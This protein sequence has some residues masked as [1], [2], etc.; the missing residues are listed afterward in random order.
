MSSEKLTVGARLA[1]GFGATTALGVLLAGLATWQMRSLSTALE[2]VAQDRIPK[3]TLATQI[4]DDLNLT[5]RSARN[6]VISAEPEFRQAELQRI[7]KA[8]EGVVERMA[9]LDRIINLPKARETFQRMS[10]QRERYGSGLDQLITLAQKGEHD[11]AAEFIVKQLRPLQNDLFKSIDE[12]MQLQ[13]DA[14]ESLATNGAAAAQSSAVTQMLL[15]LTL[16]L[17][18]GGTGWALARHLRRALGAEPQQVS[19]AVQ[20][21]AGGDLSQAIELRAG[22]AS[23]VMANVQQMQ[24]ALAAT[25]TQVRSTAEGVATASSQI[26]QGNQDLSQRTEEQASALQQTAATMTELNETV[27]HNADNARQANQLAGSASEAATRGG[28]VVGQVVQ[29]MDGISES[30]RRIADIIGVIDGIAFQTNI[31]ALNAAV[32]AARAGEQGRGFAVV[33]GEVRTLAQRS[34]EAAR[35]IKTLITRSVEQVEQ[36]SQLVGDAGTRMNEIVDAIRRVADIVGEISSASAEQ[37]TGVNQVGDAVNQMDQVTQ[38]NAALVEESAAAAESLRQQA[39]QLVDAMAVF[40][41]GRSAS[42]A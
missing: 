29:T 24:Q 37:S 25:V 5:A 10:A 13:I 26:A 30:S 17:L 11:Q 32:E 38:Q 35:E 33:A 27:R 7:A 31:L 42:R 40:Q 21:V 12:F 19:D 2:Q 22:D 8:R 23:S 20:R 3:I 1:L 39:G 6:I 16:A 4:K 36:G 34:A 28:T 41:L 14:S 15:A 18:G 9:R